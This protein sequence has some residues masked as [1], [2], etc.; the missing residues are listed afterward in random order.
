MLTWWAVGTWAAAAGGGLAMVALFL[1]HNGM[2][3]SE[4]DAIGP[5]RVF[6]HVGAAVV[7]FVLWVIYAINDNDAFGWAAVVAICIAFLIAGTFLVT[8]DQHRRRELDR[9]RGRSAA[10]GVGTDASSA[11]GIPAESHIPVVLAS[12]HG[13][14]GAG[15]LILVLLQM[16]GVGG[17]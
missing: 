4:R 6:P 9:L 15:T 5:L 1:R 14:L 16:A 3:Q 7:G 2:R 10:A 17:S 11:T 12:G 13:L 8:R